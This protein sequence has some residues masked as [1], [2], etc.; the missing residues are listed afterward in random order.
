MKLN[1]KKFIWSGV[2]IQGIVSTGE[3][4]AVTIHHAKRKLT[5]QGILIQNIYK[6]NIRFFKKSQLK[7]S[8]QKLMI[9]FRQL[10]TLFNSGIPISQSCE[11]LLKLET[12]PT[13]RLVITTLKINIA[14]GKKFSDGIRQFP[15]YFDNITCHLIQAGEESGTFATMLNRIASN[16]EKKHLLKNK[17]TQ[18]LFYPII[19]TFISTLI[20]L[21]MIIFIIPRFAELFQHKREALPWITLTVLKLSEIIRQKSWVFIIP[22]LTLVGCY[23]H[24]KTSLGLR[25]FIDR[26]IVKTPLLHLF[27]QKIIFAN[28]ARHLAILFSAGIPIVEAIQALTPATGNVFYQEA[29]SFLHTQIS[30]GQALHIA[31]QKNTLFPPLFVQM[32]KIGEESGALEHLLEK[33]ANLYE[34]EIDQ[35]L[36]QL[37]HLLEPLIM[38]ILGALIGG[39]VIAMYLPIFKLGTML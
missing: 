27:I 30:K 26:L 39:L 23:R 24:F 5:R 32:V 31:M 13:L 15:H 20:T 19:I 28:F 17:I 18:A 16:Y 29:L 11:L 8:T 4:H 7:I 21:T 10:T 12:H 35:T 36:S 22:C 9:F 14:S 37:N 33:I 6:K 34:S 2:T 25:H 38:V 3:I 1:T